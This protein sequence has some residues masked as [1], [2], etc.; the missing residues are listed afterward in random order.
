MA[1]T[2]DSGF[3][4]GDIQKLRTVADMLDSIGDAATKRRILAELVA[5]ATAVRDDMRT[6]V[7]ALSGPAPSEWKAA[8]RD[9]VRVDVQLAGPDPNI[10]VVLPRTQANR[11]PW[12]LDHGSW[13]HPLF[14]NR[15]RWF[16]QRV[17]PGWFDETGKAAHPGFIAAS[18]RGLEAVAEELADRIEALNRI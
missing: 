2:A 4:A 15:S 11:G 18:G 17:R 7:M 14:G 5:P 3:R 1:F 6:A 9:G 16:E 12:H 10:A 13:R 8:G